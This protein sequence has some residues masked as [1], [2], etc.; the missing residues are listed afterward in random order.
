MNDK[1]LRWLHGEVK[2]PPMSVAARRELGMLL[3]DVQE[4]EMLSLPQSRPMPSIGKRCHELRV[5]DEHKIWRLIHR[6]DPD[7]IVIL[8]VFEKKTNQTPLQVINDCKR[9]L[10]LYAGSQS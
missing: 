10:K 3:R 9:R 7:A 5:T 8:D 4:G 1:P 6:I 2:T